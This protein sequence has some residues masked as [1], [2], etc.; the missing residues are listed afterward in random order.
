MEES[1]PIKGGEKMEESPPIKKRESSI[2]KGEVRR[3][4]SIKG[5]ERRRE[6]SIRGRAREWNT[7][8]GIALLS[9]HL[10]W[11]RSY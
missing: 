10:K 2:R 1:P 8:Q 9:T 5:G 7:H 4:I 6:A 3:E 11:E